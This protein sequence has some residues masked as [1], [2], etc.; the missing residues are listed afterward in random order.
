VLDPFLGSGTTAAA[1]KKLN[2][3]SVGYEINPKFIPII[4]EKIGNDDMFSTSKIIEIKQKEIQQDFSALIELLPFQFVDV[5]KLDNKIDVK[6]LQYG[7][8][9]DAESEGKRE[10]FYTV[11]EIISPELLRLNNNLIVRLLGIRENPVVNGRAIDYLKGKLKGER[12]F[13]KYDEIKHDS[14]NNLLVYLY[15]ENKTFINAHLLKNNL[16]LTDNS[17]DH[18]YKNKFTTLYQGDNQA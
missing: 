13:L 16:A 4:K 15:L 18:R 7:S 14:Q 10:E 17:F 3:N 12:V 8:R 6:K 5:H 9:I 2:R 11:K 1:A